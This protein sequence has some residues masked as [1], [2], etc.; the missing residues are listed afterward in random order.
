MKTILHLL[1]FLV[2]ISISNSQEF[3]VIK[4]KDFLTKNKNMSPAQLN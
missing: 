2:I 3:D 1:L 4:Y